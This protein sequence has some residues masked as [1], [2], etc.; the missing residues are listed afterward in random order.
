MIV[1]GTSMWARVLEGSPNELSGKYQVD[2][3]HLDNDI[4]SE[5]TERGV[6]IKNDE[7][8][9]DYVTAKGVR[10]PRIMDASKRTW[11]GANIGN[12]SIIKISAKPYDWN[13]KGKSGV[14]LGLNQM[15]V[16]KLVEF[17]EDEELEAED[18]PFD[19]DDVEV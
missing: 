4:V 7:D 1:R 10:P 9:G 12:G 16:V 15:M 17:A 2:V 5:L 8:R 18:V 11:S 19:D 3:C 13:F 14:G 6:S